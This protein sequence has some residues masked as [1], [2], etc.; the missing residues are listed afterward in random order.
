MEDFS[1]IVKYVLSPVAD[2]SF[3]D[4]ETYKSSISADTCDVHGFIPNRI[5]LGKETLYNLQSCVPRSC[6]SHLLQWSWKLH[7]MGLKLCK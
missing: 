6:N 4:T 1:L 3:V 2:S 5:L 7:I